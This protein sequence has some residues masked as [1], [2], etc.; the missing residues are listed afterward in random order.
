MRRVSWNLLFLQ[1][2]MRGCQSRLAWGVW[3]E[4]FSIY[5]H[6]WSAIAS[7]LAW[8]VWV[9]MFP[10]IVRKLM[11]FGHASHEACEL[12]SASK[13]VLYESTEMSR[14]AWGVWVEMRNYNTTKWRICRHA[15]HEACELKWILLSISIRSAR[16]RLAWG[17]W[18]E[19]TE[20]T[21]TAADKRQS[22]LAWGVWVEIINT[23]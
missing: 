5:S 20:K 7:R 16:S 9:E 14:L 4:I 23:P 1:S 10:S 21:N 12:K 13:S 2:L 18:V 19:I 11:E 22:R 3:V 6:H 17:V 15:S 8:G